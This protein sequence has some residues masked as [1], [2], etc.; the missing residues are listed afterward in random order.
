MIQ[1][2]FRHDYQTRGDEKIIRLIFELGW[3]GYGLYWG[4]VELLYIGKGKIRAD[5]KMIAYELRTEQA[6]I[7]KIAKEYGLFYE[8]DGNLR[9]EAIDNRLE[10]RIS[11]N[12]AR[13]EATKRHWERR[14]NG[15]PMVDHKTT[16]GQPQDD[17]RTTIGRPEY[18][19]RIGQDRIEEYTA[20][21]IQD[22]KGQHEFDQFYLAYPRK[23]H[24]SQA[25][26]AW[27]EAKP[28]LKTCL[29]AIK[30]QSLSDEWRKENGKYIPAPDK[31]IMDRGWLN[32][33][34]SILG[35]SAA[36]I[37][38]NNQFRAQEEYNEYIER[39][40][41][42]HKEHIV[43][44]RCIFCGSAVVGPSVCGCEAYSKAFQAWKKEQERVGQVG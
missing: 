23:A 35:P 11:V 24:R 33:Q 21:G 13:A 16:T 29:E 36:Q 9:C 5:Y 32:A 18:S 17:H 6:K 28:E 25:M 31:W 44:G 38:A 34:K 19:N 7:E 10:S 12:A 14:R 22:R 27:A 4:I 40:E 3:E 2:Y 43:K 20:L 8:A 26:K 30:A 41:A 1:E 37:K 15:Q 42:W 39:Q